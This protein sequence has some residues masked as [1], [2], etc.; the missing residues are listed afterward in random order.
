MSAVHK[1]ALPFVKLYGSRLTSSSLWEEPAETRLLFLWFLVTADEDGCVLRHTLSTLARLANLPLEAVEGGLAT[2]ESADPESRTG[3][4]DGRR[5]VR[6]SDGGWRV[7]NA[8]AYRQMQTAK[9]VREAARQ[10]K[11]R[12]TAKPRS[13]SSGFDRTHEVGGRA[14]WD[15]PD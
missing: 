3:G 10:S 4:E 11:R 1:G 14:G 5:L 13:E 7:V 8:Q 12:R 2:L 9:Q 15:K 6:L